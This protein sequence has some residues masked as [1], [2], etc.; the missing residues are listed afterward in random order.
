MAERGRVLDTYSFEYENNSKY[1]KSDSFLPERD[2]EYAGALAN[3]LGTAHRVLT[4]PTEVVADLLTEAV[5]ARDMPGQADI[6]SSLIYF[7]GEIKKRHTVVLSGECSDEIFGGYPWFYRPEMLA[8]DFFPWQHD[9][10][11]RI[12]MFDEDIVQ[13]KRGFDYMSEAYRAAL[14]A[15]PVGEG[16][17]EEMLRSR[18]AT[19]L[20]TQYFMTNLLSR[21]DRM[22]MYRSVEVRVPFAD[23]RILEYVFNLPWEY[24]F[25]EGIEKS[26]LRR[27][28]EGYLPARVL[29]RKKSPYPKTQDP[30]YESLVRKMLSER[31]LRGGFL[32][33]ALDKRRLSALLSGEDGTWF[34]QLMA[35]PQLIAW[36]CQLDIWFEIY[37]VRLV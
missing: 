27:A 13:A 35:R 2:E 18:R 10:H 11:T 17:S 37:R 28:M 1:F 16:E 29:W 22:S 6:D 34:G 8:R 31:L 4:A 19:W 21:K 12:G 25:E 5:R 7:C 9:P 30:T 3:A 24:K 33:E 23:H 36:L 32:A 26:L 20:S 14:A 15:C